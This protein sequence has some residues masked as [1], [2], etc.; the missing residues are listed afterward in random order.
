[1]EQYCFI[2]PIV[3]GNLFAVTGHF[4]RLVPD[5]DVDD[6]RIHLETYRILLSDVDD[7][8]LNLRPETSLDAIVSAYNSITQ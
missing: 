6:D 3:D 1:M 5:D 8:N 7:L 2:S 4:P